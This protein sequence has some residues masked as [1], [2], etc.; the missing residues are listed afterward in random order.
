MPEMILPSLPDDPRERI[1]VMTEVYRKQERDLVSRGASPLHAMIAL[2]TAMVCSQVDYL[3]QTQG[4][5]TDSDLDFLTDTYRESLRA[6]LAETP[7][8]EHDA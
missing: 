4:E 6:V 2:Q 8:R 1:V 7:Q 3:L 5:I